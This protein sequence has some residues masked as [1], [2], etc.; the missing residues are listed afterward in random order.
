MEFHNLGFNA[1]FYRAS[2]AVAAGTTAINGTS[3]D[4]VGSFGG[5]F[6]GVCYIAALG[7]LTAS[8]VTTLKV[9]GSV[10]NS[11]WTGSNG[12]LL[13][14]HQGPANDADSNKLLI[15][16]GY[17]YQFRYL[18][19]VLSRG[20]AN[21]VLDSLIGIAYNAHSLPITTQDSTVSV[22]AAGGSGMNGSGAAAPVNV[23]RYAGLGT[24]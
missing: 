8:Q 10:D 9:Q 1:Y 6:D 11:T 17:R 4:M 2:N 5:P 20:T 19:P 24:A 15:T 12:D 13:N 14:T 3:I 16:D 7:T 22:P 23:V 18:R 21:A